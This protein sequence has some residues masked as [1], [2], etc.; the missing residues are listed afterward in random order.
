MK[1][2]ITTCLLG[3]ALALIGCSDPAE[4][5]Y[6]TARFEEVQNNQALAR[7]AYEKIIRDHPDSPYA[8]KATERLAAIGGTVSN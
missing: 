2:F 8:A 1:R 5:L 3:F 4:E 6:E 7:K